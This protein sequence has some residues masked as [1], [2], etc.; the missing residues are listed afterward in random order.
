MAHKL[1]L[2]TTFSLMFIFVGITVIFAKFIY[3]N[4]CYVINCSPA[5][6]E[7]IVDVV[8]AQSGKEFKFQSISARVPGWSS[9]TEAGP[10]SVVITVSYVSLNTDSSR[11]NEEAN[12]PIKSL[13]FDDKSLITNSHLR[14]AW[15]NRI[16]PE[17]WQEKLQ[18]VTV[19]PR[20]AFDTTWA[21]AKKE[22]G[23]SSDN[24]KSLSAILIFDL[25]GYESIWQVSCGCNTTVLIVNINAQTGQIISVG[26]N[27]LPR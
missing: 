9:Y 21:F 6:W 4:R 17:D 14:N 7:K 26:K 20:D 11:A 10:T 13:E 3:E 19:R 23:L 22:V 12:H 1:K 5:L 25:N 15:T 18:R 27:A 24:V 2:I 8:F 16:P